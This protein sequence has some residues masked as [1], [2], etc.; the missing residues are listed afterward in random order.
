LA[1]KNII[2]SKHSAQMT[3]ATLVVIATLAMHSP[4]PIRA[5]VASSSVR[6]NPLSSGPVHRDGG[7][8]G[9]TEM[10]DLND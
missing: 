2:G 7:P 8:A 9:L 1:E 10:L 4:M 5:S 3:C 6:M